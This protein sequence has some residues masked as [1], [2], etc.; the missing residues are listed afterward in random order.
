MHVSSEL[1]KTNI[2]CIRRLIVKIHTR[3]LYSFLF[4]VLLLEGTFASHCLSQDNSPPV[5]NTLSGPVVGVW[6]D[7]IRVFKGIPY[8]RPPVDELRFAPPQSAE[9]WTEPR[10]CTR[11]GDI[12]V[13]NRGKTSL[14]PST[15]SMSEDCLNLNIW[16]PADVDSN[17]KLPVYVFIHGGAYATGSGSIPIY[18]GTGFAKQDIVVVSI[19]YR[20]NALGF[21]ASNETFARY[22]TTGNWGHLDQVKALEWVRDN[23]AAFGGDRDRVTIGGESAG[24]YSV[25]AL[26]LSPMA[27][28]LFRRAIMESG[29]ILAVP[30]ISH[31][32]KGDLWRSIRLCSMLAS[33]VGAEDSAEGLAKLRGVDAGVLARLAKFQADQTTLLAFFL[34]S[35]FDGTFL[36]VNPLAALERGE[37]NKVDL[38]FGFNS[39]EGTLFAAADADENTYK[40]MA[41]MEL[42][43][44]A[45]EALVLFPVN[46]SVSAGERTRRLLTYTMFTAGMKVFA[47]AFAEH[48]QNVYAY[49]FDAAT[50]RTIKAGLGATH[51]LE[52]PFVFNTLPALGITD[53][54]NAKLS[55]EM[56]VRWANFIKTGDPNKG[57]ASSI[58]VVWPTY[59]KE[60]PK[61]IRFGDQVE[62]I[63]FP[64]RTTWNSWLNF[65]SAS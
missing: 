50:A 16:T 34:M 57:A 37:F 48:G 7:G 13:Q 65:F 59:Q 14:T 5:V 20:L 41:A 60:T 61:V 4:A 54:A 30:A 62:A 27:T 52:L 39:D 45:E 10:D 46:E 6:S 24:S 17:Q 43:D 18:D 58:K 33:I 53:E 38:L 21:Y 44:K 36:P 56:H 64:D 1:D 11:F 2:P 55:D 31:Y 8:A 3:L 26:I 19:N 51:A 42:G 32:A 22:G 29:T 63:A 9:P 40:M 12:A 28:G 47:D 15:I 23:I 49:N 35:V 25:S